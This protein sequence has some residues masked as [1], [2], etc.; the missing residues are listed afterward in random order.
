MLELYTRCLFGL[1][2]GYACCGGVQ[3]FI[4]QRANEVSAYKEEVPREADFTGW[5]YSGRQL[6]QMVFPFL[7]RI[8]N[9]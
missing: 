6:W 5:Q 1:E 4:V 2:K 7:E 3:T 8:S 9:N